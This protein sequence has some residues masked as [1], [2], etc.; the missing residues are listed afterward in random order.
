[1]KEMK[2]KLSMIIQSMR[3]LTNHDKI[4]HLL[5][6]IRHRTLSYVR[7]VSTDQHASL[8]GSQVQKTLSRLKRHLCH[9]VIF[10]F[11][12]TSVCGPCLLC[13]ILQDNILG[14]SLFLNLL[15]SDPSPII[16]YACQSLLNSRLVNLID[17]TLVS[18]DDF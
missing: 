12:G 10:S 1:M 5:R 3:S 4:N 17:V 13:R 16:G 6:A 15:L 8:M 14:N 9:G 11:A 18:E 2:G 7:Y